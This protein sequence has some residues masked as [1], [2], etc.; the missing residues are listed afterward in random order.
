MRAELGSWVVRGAGLAIGLALVYGV[1]QLGVAAVGV[2]V[3]LF[4]AVLLASALEPI[5]GGLRTR[6]PVGRGWSVLI[7]YAGFVLVVA[8]FALLVVPAAAAQADAVVRS[9]PAFFAETRAWASELRPAFLARSAETVVES[10]QRL[11]GPAAQPDADL[12]IEVGG[13]AA[14]IAIHVA[15]V[16]SLVFFWIVEHARLQ[17]YAL[18]FLPAERR[19]GARDAWNEIESRLGG[20]VRGQLILMG[21]IGLATGIAY[22]VLGLP[23]A[24]L[25]GLVAGIAEAIPMIGPLLGAI[26]AVLVAATVSPELAVVVAMVYVVLQVVEG[27]VLVPIVMR[28]TVGLSPFLVL[29]SLLFGGA[30]AG[31]A[32][33]FLAVPMVAAIEI[34]AARFQAREVPVLQDVSAVTGD[35]EPVAEAS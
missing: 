15:T 6:L 17:R 2:L 5:V 4:L 21:V 26:P 33:A 1:V 18:S 29:A 24:L 8:G 31:I 20:W 27:Y 22:S 14:E 23:G 3:L 10:A 32:G 28:N 34:V 7:V 25:L 13:T 19:T 11:I 12:I 9:L 16:L 30:V 35:D